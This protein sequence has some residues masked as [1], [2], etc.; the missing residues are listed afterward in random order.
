[1]QMQ[2][3]PTAPS[4]ISSQAVE[5]ARLVAV[6][7]VNLGQVLLIDRVHEL[8]SDVVERHR[9][10]MSLAGIAGKLAR[11][12]WILWLVWDGTVRAVLATELYTDV[13][14]MK[15]CRVPFCTGDS[16]KQWVHLLSEIEAWARSEGC[17]K[18]DMIARKG[19]AR[20][21]ADYRMTHV[22][23]EKDLT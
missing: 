12:E 11:K 22:L 23:L 4:R 14:G 9:G 18:I 21:L 3:A 19:W 10:E 20:H 6:N 17:E 15:R 16:A 8:L 1:M 13:G 5:P 7:P 2:Q